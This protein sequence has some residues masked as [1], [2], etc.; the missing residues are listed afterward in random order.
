MKLLI[1]YLNVMLSYY[2]SY[3]N[4][5]SAD[6]IYLKQLLNLIINHKLR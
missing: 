1:S 5:A 3:P 2:L 4:N 6:V